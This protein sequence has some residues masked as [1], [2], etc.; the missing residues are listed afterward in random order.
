MP[1]A[2]VTIS[3]PAKINMHLSVVG[4]REDGYHLLQ[5]LM[6]K[7]SLADRLTITPVKNGLS[8]KVDGAEDLPADDGNLVI[9]AARS[10]FENTG[11]DGGAEFHLSKRIPVAAGLG[12]GS[13]DAAAALAGLNELYGRPLNEVQLSGIGL[14]LGADV[15]FFLYPATAAWAEGIGEKLG[16]APELPRMSFLLV[17][18]GWPLSTAWVYKNVKIKLTN[19]PLSH[20]PSRFN[21]RS[22]TIGSIL[23]NDLEA[24]VLPHYPEL[25]TIKERLLSAGAIG[26]L[27]TGSG[28][29]VFGVFFDRETM[30]RACVELEKER[31][32]KWLVIPAQPADESWPTWEGAPEGCDLLPYE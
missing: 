24:V 22:F 13:S 31:P 26:A 15:P 11:I 14:S 6:V 25:N 23:H 12:G 20:I 10:F 16:T 9:R 30:E 7:L 21:E 27:M 4:R 19:R 28:P 3:A 18:P 32:G 8:L 2:T 1:P 29:T 5:T 17:N